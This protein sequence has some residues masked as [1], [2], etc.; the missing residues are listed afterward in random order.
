MKIQTSDG[1]IILHLDGDPDGVTPI[2]GTAYI[3]CLYVKPEFRHSGLG[4]CLLALAVY[5]AAVNE[6]RV[7]LYAAPFETDKVNA[8]GGNHEA[9]ERLHSWYI[10]NNFA[11]IDGK[12]SC[13]ISIVQ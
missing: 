6:K 13:F 10:R 4:S 11:P 1:H 2:P 9:R 8:Y 3:E 7:T 5:I 12:D